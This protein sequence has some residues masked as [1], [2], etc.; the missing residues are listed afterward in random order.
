MYSTRVHDLAEARGNAKHYLSRE[1]QA[2]IRALSLVAHIIE[3]KY[4]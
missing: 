1:A 2:G 4:L 3:I